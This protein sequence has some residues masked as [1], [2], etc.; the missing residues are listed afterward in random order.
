MR[1]LAI[2]ALLLLDR[3][4]VHRSPL[5]RSGGGTV[6]RSNGERARQP[7]SDALFAQDDRQF[8]SADQGFRITRPDT[9]WA[10]QETPPPSGA[11]YALR[12]FRSDAKT[13]TSVTVYVTDRGT[14]ADLN[15]VLAATEKSHKAAPQCSNVKRGEGRIDGKKAPSIIFD[16]KL[17]AETYRLEQF[18]ALDGDR[19]FVVQTAATPAADR[20]ALEAIAATFALAPVKGHRRLAARCGSDIDWAKDWEDAARRAREGGRLVLVVFELYGGFKVDRMAPAAIFTDPDI[21][22]LAKERLV[23]L[24][25]DYGMRAPIRNPAVYG[26]GGGAFGRALVLFTPDGRA[27]GDTWHFDP[28]FLDAYIRRALRAAAPAPA[29]ADAATHVR[30]GEFDEALPLLKSPDTAR[31]LL[32][33]AQIHRRSRRGPEALDDLRAAAA[34]DDGSLAPDLLAEEALVLLRTKK[35]ADAVKLLERLRADHP[36]SERAVEA[37]YWLGAARMDK[38]E[39]EKLVAESPDSRWAWRA[40]AGLDH[41]EKGAW[42]D[43]LDWADEATY[44]AAD[45]SPSA[46]LG[47]DAVRKAEEDGVAYLLRTQ[48]AD[49]SWITPS[50]VGRTSPSFIVA[51]TSICAGSLLRFGKKDEVKRAL[52]YVRGATLESKSLT[53]FNYRIWGR[54][55]AL[56]FL[57]QCA[58]AG[59]GEKAAVVRAMQAHVDALDEEQARGGGWSYADLREVGGAQDPSMGFV[60][61]AVILSLLDAKEAGARVPDRMVAEAAA[62]VAKMK[63]P[64]GCFSYQGGEGKPTAESSLRSP[65]YAL[66]LARAGSGDVEGLR[67][68]LGHCMKFRLHVRK[69]RTKALCHTGQEGTASYYLFYGWRHA[70]EAVRRLPKGEGDDARRALVEDVLSARCEDG[71]FLDS[72]VEGRTYGTGM[73]L[74][75]LGLLSRP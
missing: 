53:A 41:V 32:L 75:A 65:L 19:V 11:R 54:C 28:P 1:I 35:T 44:A 4:T 70:A 68:S 3:C 55:F 48:R 42:L 38:P 72:P 58:Q 2:A 46:P 63:G 22:T 56:R 15:A 16:Y 12:V 26:I 6:E 45:D 67:A 18:F 37:R 73:A 31:D 27:V 30:R 57:A 8:E 5:D 40:A 47:A 23:V 20:A 10:F 34:K 51:T 71:G 7:C 60:T 61:A 62:C 43:R 50:Q 59:V 13:E 64:E 74:A 24:R 39:W 17:A 21:V 33:R 69:E 25:W 14:H 29:P 52:E 36:K 66:A 49:G 9:G